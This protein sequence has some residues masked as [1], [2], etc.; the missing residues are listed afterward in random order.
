MASI[1]KYT[2][3]QS[4]YQDQKKDIDAAIQQCLDTDNFILGTAVESFEHKVSQ[5]LGCDFVGVASGTS[6]LHLALLAL[7]IKSGDEVIVPSMTFMSTAEMVS[8]VGAV[9]VFADIDQYHLLDIESVKKKITDRTRAIIVVDLYGQC[10]DFAQWQ[11]FRSQGIKLI[12]DAAQSW[13]IQY[14]G[15]NPHDLVD[16]QCWSFYP[17]KN[18]SAI[19][20][21]GGV[22]GSADLV[23][24]VRQLSNHGRSK[25]YYHTHLGWNQRIDA[26]QA[27]VLSVKIDRQAWALTNKRQAAAMYSKILCG[28]E[29]IVPKVAHWADHTWNQYVVQVPDRN[30]IFELLDK[31][32][33]KCGLQYPRPL[34]RQPAFDYL[35]VSRLPYSENHADSCLCLP[36]HAY[37]THKQVDRVCHT[38]L[39][40]LGDGK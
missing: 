12:Q 28:T 34:H 29:V 7:D 8:Q 35:P 16:A 31:A 6:A 17:G 23:D 27:A 11:E 9:P 21:A 24:R 32:S 3:L 13:G 25:K 37:L 40:H 18:L 15:S 2:D 5:Q 36:M 26:V 22:S 1:I 38:L 14:K 30:Q 4:E 10:V 33:I 19:G 20:D 39:W